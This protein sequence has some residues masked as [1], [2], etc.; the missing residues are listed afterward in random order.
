MGLFF[1]T[2]ICNGTFINNAH[3][4][5]VDKK[6]IRVDMHNMSECSIQQFE[7]LNQGQLQSCYGN[8][9]FLCEICESTWELP[10]QSAPGY[11]FIFVSRGVKFIPTLVPVLSTAEEKR[12]K[13]DIARRNVFLAEVSLENAKKNLAL[14]QNSEYDSDVST[15]AATVTRIA[16]GVDELD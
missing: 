8:D 6:E 1:T 4:I 14:A 11:R 7:Q 12:E 3:A 5:L 10:K 16:T 15:S 2:F 9:V 13:I